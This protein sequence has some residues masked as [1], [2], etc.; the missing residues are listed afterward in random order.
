M[1]KTLVFA[2]LA[3]ALATGAQA[4]LPKSLTFDGFCDG[5]TKIQNVGEAV[6]ANYDATNCGGGTLGMF[7]L[8]AK[9]LSGPG[10]KG[11]VLS[12][13][14][15]EVYGDYY[16]YSI[17]EDGTYTLVFSNGGVATGTWTAGFT[18]G[19]QKKSGLKSTR[20]PR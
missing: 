17:K 1:K 13:K 14:S 2:G 3:L 11:V 19:D 20:D 9:S 12:E 10:T 7:G 5:I 6:L 4:K 15:F 18:A 16:V 8:P